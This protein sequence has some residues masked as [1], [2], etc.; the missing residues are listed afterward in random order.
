MEASLGLWSMPVKTY[1]AFGTETYVVAR[2]SAVLDNCYIIS[3]FDKREL[4]QSVSLRA[5]NGDTIHGYVRRH[6]T[7]Y[8][9]LMEILEDG[10]VH[11]VTLAIANLDE[12]TDYS[13]VVAVLSRTWIVSDEAVIS[14]DKTYV[15]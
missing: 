13:V 3:F 5:P 2:V 15:K 4:F 1:L 9:E 8:K 12:H 6:S 10:N 11:D 14:L 7:A